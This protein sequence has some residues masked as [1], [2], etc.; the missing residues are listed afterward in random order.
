MQNLDKV[1]RKNKNMVSR[2][3]D[4]EL[5]LVPIFKSDKDINEIY[6]FNDTAGKIWDLIDG[7][8]TLAKIRED[9]LR[10]FAVDDKTLDKH[11]AEFINDLQEI[12][13]IQ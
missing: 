2:K 11:L 9:L 13:A 6:S 8:R 5:I 12:K 7:K 1:F 4:K 10:K 3:I